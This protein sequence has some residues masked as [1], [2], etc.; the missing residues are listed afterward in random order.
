MCAERDRARAVPVRINL[1][2][3]NNSLPRGSQNNPT[4]RDCPRLTGLVT[5]DT[6]SQL[7]NSG[8]VHARERTIC[9]T[10][11]SLLFISTAGSDRQPSTG[12]LLRENRSSNGV[13]RIIVMREMTDLLSVC[14]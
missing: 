6:A 8:S 13:R 4:K 2:N 14:T 9:Y 1:W 11:R 7:G 3:R 5:W 10:T 12:T